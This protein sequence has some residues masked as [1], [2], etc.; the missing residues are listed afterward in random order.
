MSRFTP[1]N[2]EHLADVVMALAPGQVVK[3][4]P[5]NGPMPMIGV[6]VAPGDGDFFALPETERVKY[7]KASLMAVELHRDVWNANPG[8]AT[9][10][11]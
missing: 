4:M 2:E 10:Y 1:T 7:W 11:R 5:L 3:L 6:Y 8:K 9:K